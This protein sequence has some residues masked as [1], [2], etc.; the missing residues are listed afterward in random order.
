MDRKMA[1]KKIEIEKEIADL[2]KLNKKVE[3]V[4]QS[5]LGSMGFMF[6]SIVGKVVSNTVKEGMEQDPEKAIAI[7]QRIHDKIHQLATLLSTK[8]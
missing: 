2:F 6:G 7:L 5:E 8:E 1:L 4:V 3:N